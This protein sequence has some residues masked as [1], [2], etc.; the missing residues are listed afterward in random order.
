MNRRKLHSI[1]EKKTNIQ[2]Y[3]PIG[4][5]KKYAK[6]RIWFWK[7]RKF[8]RELHLRYV[9]SERVSPQV[10]V[11]IAKNRSTNIITNALKYSSE[12]CFRIVQVCM[13]SGNSS[14]ISW[15]SVRNVVWISFSFTEISSNILRKLQ[16]PL[17]YPFNTD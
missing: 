17:Q 12:H 11:K 2:Y 9:S 7:F 1:A 6:N 4:N 14:E 13:D 5:P 8:H 16:W 10:T 15:S 3:M